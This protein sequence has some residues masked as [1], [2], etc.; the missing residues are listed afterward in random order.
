MNPDVSYTSSIMDC[1]GDGTFQRVQALQQ[2]RGSDVQ[3]RA[4]SSTIYNLPAR[5]LGTM[6]DNLNHSVISNPTIVDA[7][8]KVFNL[9]EAPQWNA[10]LPVQFQ[11]LIVEPLRQIESQEVLAGLHGLGIILDGLDECEEVTQGDIDFHKRCEIIRLIANSILEHKTPFRWLI[12]SRPEPDVVG[13]MEQYANRKLI[14]ESSLPA[15]SSTP[16]QTYDTGESTSQTVCPTQAASEIPR[17]VKP[18]SVS[19]RV[20]PVVDGIPFIGA[21]EATPSTIPFSSHEPSLKALSHNTPRASTAETISVPLLFR[22]QLPGADSGGKHDDVDADIRLYLT[23]SL[24]EIGKSHGLAEGWGLRHIETIVKNSAKLFIYA[25][26]IIRFIGDPRSLAKKILILN[27][28]Y[29]RHIHNNV[30]EIA[31]VLALDESRFRAACSFLQSVLHLENVTTG[32]VPAYRIQFYHASFMEFMEDP[33]RSEERWL[34]GGC[35]DVLRL[36]IID[37]IN[38]MHV[39]SGDNS[40]SV[41]IPFPWASPRDTDGKLVYVSHLEVLARLWALRGHPVSSAIAKA[42]IGIN[43]SMI[44]HLLKDSPFPGIFIYPAELRENVCHLFFAAISNTFL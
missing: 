32:R 15:A 40:L 41:E 44:P 11:E 2:E 22:F 25:A 9:N 34:Y 7:F 18:V 30:I 13:V 5:T 31:N 20:H 27:K 12:V 1:V 14:V 4:N 17:T 37:R 39:H 33:R 42:L 10:S 29:S 43:F 26:T 8:L 16:S 38:G 35:L 19:D 21:S 28:T 3:S 23:I 36:E 6:L 24:K